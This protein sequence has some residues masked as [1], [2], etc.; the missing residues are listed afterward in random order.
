MDIKLSKGLSWLLRHHIVDQGLDV[1]SDGYVLCNDI[2]KLNKFK[3]YTLEDIK[4]VVES[5]DK[6]RFKLK[7]E[8]NLWFIRANQ[9]H[10]HE[11]ASHIK[12]EELLT[13]MTEPLLVVVHGT[14]VKNYELIKESGLKQIGR[15]HIHFSISDNFIEGNKTQSGIRAN[16]RILIYLDMK[17]AMEDGIEF[18]MSDNKVVLSQGLDGL[19][20]TKYFS[21][22]ID[23]KTGSVI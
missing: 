4:R 14:T 7:E 8:N 16:S 2:L 21:K 15:S 9:G 10:S 1:S 5:N 17:L 23:T 3:N 13:K 18:Y 19:I 6:Q 11:V 20:S 22:V 12:Q